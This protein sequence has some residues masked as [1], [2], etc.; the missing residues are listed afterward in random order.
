MRNPNPQGMANTLISNFRA[1]A[2]NAGLPANFFQANPNNT[3]GAIVTLNSHKT[4]YNSLQ[5]ELRRRL[6]QGLQFQTS[7]VYGN[8]MQTAFYTFR[9]DLYWQ[10]DTGSEGDLTHQFKGNV[11]YDLPFGQGRR[12]GG[13]AN[14]LIDRIIG[15]WQLG[16]NARV[17]SGQM[18]D[19]GGVRLVGWTAKD[20]QKAYKLRFDDA[21][22]QIFMFPEDVITNTILAF[23]TSN[24]SAT[25]YS[26]AAPTGRYFAPANGPDC[27]EVS[28]GLGECPGA[29]RSLVLTGPRFWEADLRV[30]KRT[31]VVSR[32][33]IELAVEALNV[34]NHA[35]FVPDN[36]VNSATLSNYLVTGLTGTNQ[37]RVIQLVSRINW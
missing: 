18:V 28:S 14:G 31:A 27:I 21:A 11:V 34:F 10:R 12:F 32:V 7:Y 26:G 36:T 37:A 6:A 9:R 17:Q 20:V 30:S 23:S 16:L 8:A 22:K 24:T 13:S 29:V 33:N 25:G 15:G 3:G 2:V 4:R 1:N 35:N 5:V 19:V